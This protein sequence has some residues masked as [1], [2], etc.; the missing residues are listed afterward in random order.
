MYNMIVLKVSVRDEMVTKIISYGEKKIISLVRANLFFYVVN[1]II[2]CLSW[3]FCSL[4]QL[5]IVWYLNLETM[6]Q[7]IFSIGFLQWLV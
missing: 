6:I 5:K 3:V 7:F 4:K 2:F 1:D